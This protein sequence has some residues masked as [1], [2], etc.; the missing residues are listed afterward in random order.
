MVTKVLRN[1]PLA[2]ASALG[3]VGLAAATRDSRFEPGVWQPPEPPA[4]EA[5]L[6]PNR[7]LGGLETVVRCEGP[8]DVVFDDDGHLYTGCE[9]GT[10]RKT[11]EPVAGNTHLDLEPVAYTG[12]RPLALDFDDDELLVCVAGVGLVAVGPDRHSR[13]LSARADDRPI[14]FADDLHIGGDG[15]V[16]FTD[17]SRHDQYQDELLELGDT[18]RLLSYDPGSGDTRVE[19]DGLGFA[20]GVAPG[21]DGDSLLITETSRYRVLRYWYRGARA[22][23]F[24]FVVTNLPGF[25]DNIDANGDGTYWLSIPSLRDPLV[26]W[27][28]ERPAIARQLGKLPPTVLSLLDADPYGLVIRI[29]AAGD[30]IES[31]HDPHGNGGVFGVTSATPHEGD[32]YLGTLFGERVVRYPLK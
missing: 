2:V 13:V 9:D 32:L 3:A 16:Y 7:E 11:V 23:E 1:H 18:G 30:I 21:P 6:A 24:E 25:P 31:L 17:A 10:V 15:R 12:G 27:V 29:D 26:D 19:L 14:V 4:L 28:H 5:T 22:G 8:E 20:N